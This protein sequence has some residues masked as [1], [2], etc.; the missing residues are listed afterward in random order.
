LYITEGGVGSL[1]SGNPTHPSSD[2]LVDR[3]TYTQLAKP[4][5]L[6]TM[7][8]DPAI[9]ALNTTYITSYMGYSLHHRS[10]YDCKL[11]PSVAIDEEGYQ[12]EKYSRPLGSTTFEV[13]RYSQAGM[14]T[15]ANYCTGE[16]EDA[17]CYQVTPGADHEGCTVASEE[18]L[19]T[20]ELITNP[21]FGKLI[22]APN[23]WSCQNEAAIEGLCQ[24]SYSVP[25]N[26]LAY[27]DSREGWAAGDDGLI[28]HMAAQAW[29]EFLSPSIHPI[30]DLH[31]SSPTN[32]WAVGDGA[33][34]LR[35]DGSS[36]I[37]I[38]PYH[39]P[40]EGPGGSTQWLFGVDVV[41]RD[42]AWMVG[43]IRGID[44]KDLPYVL[45][46]DGTDLIEQ[47]TFPE[48]NCGLNAVL[49]VGNG[50]VLAVGGSDLGAVALYWDGSEWFKTVIPGSDILYTLSQAPDGMV[51][52][53]GMEIA[54]DQSD[55]RG[56]LFRWDGSTWQRLAVPPLTGGIYAVSAL[57]TGQVVLGGDFNAL[58]TVMSWEP[59]TAGI[60]G[61]G[62][63]ADIEADAQGITWALTHS[64]NLFRLEIG[65]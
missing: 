36:W 60:A 20:Y 55:T 34:V 26:A 54:R 19:A 9:W 7:Q 57:P 48:C 24:I 52:A 22:T 65:P 62:W 33:Q 21:F 47:S 51:W 37:E 29:G 53:A 50:K 13:A 23:H 56:T 17:T 42:D 27:T 6:V 46:W 10:I 16:G 40:G 35:W 25:L 15:F 1:T 31:F 64:G 18:V 49:S 2:L 58:W 38:L 41:S 8:Y 61:Y 63:I 4:V 44:G 32:G 59:I 45:H 30:Y 11:T 12:V 43:G 39:G 14:L 28:F 5:S 3:P